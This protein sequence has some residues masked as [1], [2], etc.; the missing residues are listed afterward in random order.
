MA[1][2]PESLLL[3]GTRVASARESSRLARPGRDKQEQ[4][5]AL[6]SLVSAIA[7]TGY[8]RSVGVSGG[9]RYDE[10]RRR[11]PIQPPEGTAPYVERMRSGEANVLWPGPCSTFATTAGTTTGRARLVPHTEAMAAHF[12]QAIRTVF[13]CYA[14]RAGNVEM[15]RE[16]LFVLPGDDSGTEP[17]LCTLFSANLPSWTRSRLLDP[18]TREDRGKD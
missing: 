18:C 11:I 14:A 4:S 3:L 7:G 8:G 5:A 9:M 6:I 16:S 17:D 13:A 15:L 1:V 10:F 12:R 2:L